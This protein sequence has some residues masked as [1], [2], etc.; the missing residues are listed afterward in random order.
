VSSPIT[1]SGFNNIDFNTVLTALMAQASQPLTALQTQQSNLNARSSTYGALTAQLTT[2]NTAASALGQTDGTST[3]VATSSDSSTISATATAGA[4]VG[5]YDVVVDE[6]ARAQ[7]TASAST[8]PDANTTVVATAGTLTIG[9]VV[10]TV[11]SSATLQQLAADINGTSGIGVTASVVQSGTN[12]FRLVLTGQ[13][14]G[15]ASAFTIANGLSGGT[16]VTFTDTDADGLSG[17]SAADNAQQ[18]TDAHVLVNNVD[19][20]S[21]TNTLTDAIPGVTL[22][23]LRKDPTDTVGINVASDGTALKAN[24]QSFITAYNAF[25]SFATSQAT[26]AANG[27]P[28]SIGRDSLL[29]GLRNEL[30]T[31]INQAYGSGTFT[32]LAEV[33][34]EFTQDGTLQLNDSL[35]DS[36]VAASP[37]DVQNLFSGTSGAFATIS[38]NLSEYVQGSGLISTTQATLAQ[39]SARLD[40]QIAA[41]QDRLDI[42]KTALQEEFTAADTA[43]S[44]LQSQS[45]SISGLSTALTANQV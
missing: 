36:A 2:L 44:A 1:F 6:L 28:T 19:V 40:T 26:T 17:N 23:L 42:Q 9:G 18:A 37:D 4:P 7:V 31:D 38:S 13:S 27:D 43:I 15:A 14:T 22:Q 10:V 30:R 35:F 45:S 32:R 5:R 29:R 33:G 3:V 8:A 12:A 24:V 41:M 39:E 11:G 25:V 16:G 21:A 34:V 20:V